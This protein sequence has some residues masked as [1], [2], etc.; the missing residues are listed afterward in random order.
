MAVYTGYW[1]KDNF[2]WGPRE[3][4]KFWIQDGWIW[5]PRNGGRY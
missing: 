4:G 1:I 2:I 5:G 3:S